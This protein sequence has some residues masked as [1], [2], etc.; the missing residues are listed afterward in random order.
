MPLAYIFASIS[1]VFTSA[2]IGLLID[3]VIRKKQWY[4]IFENINFISNGFIN[5]VIGV[6]AFKYILVNSFWAK[7]NPNLLIKEKPGYDSLVR[8]RKDMTNAEISHLIGFIFVMILITIS[9]KTKF[10]E[11]IIF[12]LFIANIIFHIYPVLVQQYNK[13]RIDKLLRKYYK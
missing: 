7:A 10:H 8:L 12:P 6:N 9:I 13:R 1:I 5:K 2:V 4:T 3:T 11:G